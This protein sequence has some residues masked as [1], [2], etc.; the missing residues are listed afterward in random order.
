MFDKGLIWFCLGFKFAFLVYIKLV[1]YVKILLPARRVVI[2]AIDQGAVT[3]HQYGPSLTVLHVCLHP[4][5]A[6]E[7]AQ[8]HHVPKPAVV[9]REIVIGKGSLVEWG[10]GNE[11]DIVNPHIRMVAL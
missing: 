1:L 8:E 3:L 6:Q 9:Q 10:R 2:Q 4:E 11:E 7:T 5:T